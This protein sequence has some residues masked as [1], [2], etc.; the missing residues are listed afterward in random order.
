MLAD[1]KSA[2]ADPAD[3]VISRVFAAPRDLVWKCFTEAA[4]MQA[5]FGPKGSTPARPRDR[6]HHDNEKARYRRSQA[7]SRWRARCQ[8]RVM[9][10]A[11]QTRPPTEREVII[12]RVF[13]APRALVFKAWT[14]AAQLAQWGG[15]ARLHQ[16]GLRIRGA[17]RRQNSYPYARDGRHALSDERRNPRD[18]AA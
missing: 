9:K 1:T 13:D 11:E 2:E 5:W 6:H 18:R 8:E 16:S 3:F 14:D 15:P 10:I 7:G 12:T 17:P 4:R